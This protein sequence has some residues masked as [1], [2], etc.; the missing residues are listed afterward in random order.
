MRAVRTWTHHRFSF[1]LPERHK[2]PLAKYELLRDAVV[3]ELGA[4]V[5]EADPV[6]WDALALVHDGDLLRRIRDGELSLRETRGLG[7]PWSPELVERGRRSVAGTVG[8]RRARRST[9]ASR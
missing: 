2:F 8:P 4:E 9:W 3:H 5:L 1:P 7:L 6:R